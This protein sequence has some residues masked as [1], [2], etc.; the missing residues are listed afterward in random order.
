MFIKLYE[1][2]LIVFS[3]GDGG[4]SS[5]NFFCLGRELGSKSTWLYRLRGHQRFVP[6]KIAHKSS[7]QHGHGSIAEPT[8]LLYLQPLNA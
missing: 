3:G 8:M 1:V 7:T 6:T 4:R 2:R 5:K